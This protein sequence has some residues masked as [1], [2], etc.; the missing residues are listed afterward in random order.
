MDLETDEEHWKGKSQLLTVTMSNSVGGFTNFDDSATPDDGKFHVTIVP[1]LDI[2]QFIFYLPRIMRGKFYTIPGIT[3]FTAKRMKIKAKEKSVGT[4]T[5]GD[6]TDDLPV[7]LS[8]VS[9][10]LAVY[11]PKKEE[12]A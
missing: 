6:T 7:E 11:S 1:S 8:V 9:K 3:Y 5:D 2:F 4:R 12:Q 10:G